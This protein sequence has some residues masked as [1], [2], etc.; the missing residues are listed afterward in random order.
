MIFFEFLNE[1]LYSYKKICPFFIAGQ[2]T[3]DYYFSLTIIQLWP[4]YKY[5]TDL[6]L[7]AVAFAAL[8]IITLL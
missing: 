4:Q 5:A 7:D 8:L 2:N 1:K 3:D 6:P